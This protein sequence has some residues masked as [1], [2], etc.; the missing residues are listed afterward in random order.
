M[1]KR[2]AKTAVYIIAALGG[3]MGIICGGGWLIWSYA[4]APERV[5]KRVRQD[6]QKQFAGRVQVRW[7]ELSP[8]LRLNV[9]G[10]KVFLP[11]GKRSVIAIPRTHVRF[12]PERFLHGEQV[13]RRVELSS[14]ELR[15]V[16]DVSAD[17]WNLSELLRRR[18]KKERRKEVPRSLLQDGLYVENGSVSIRSRKIFKSP[19]PR[20]VEGVNLRLFRRSPGGPLWNLTGNVSRGMLKGMVFSGRFADQGFWLDCVIEDL[21]VNKALLKRIPVGKD[22]EELFHPRGRV[23]GDIG[24]HVPSDQSG[25]RYNA[26]IDLR[27]LNSRTK[28]YGAR[29]YEMAGQVLIV[30]GKVIFRDISGRLPPDELGLKA[31]ECQPAKVRINGEYD[32]KSKNSWVRIEAADMPLTRESVKEI[33]EVGP[34]IW[35][36]LQPDGFTDVSIKVE[37]APDKKT[38]FGVRADLKEVNLTVNELPFNPSK[39]VGEVDVTEK[40]VKLRDV[41]GVVKQGNRTARLILNGTFDTKGHPRD[42]TV[43]M[44]NFRLSEKTVRAIP[45]FGEDFW[46]AFRPDGTVEGTITLRDNGEKL[47]VAGSIHLSDATLRPEF[48]PLTLHGVTATVH[49][50]DNG[51]Q[52]SRLVGDMKVVSGEDEEKEHVELTGQLEPDCRSGTI[53]LRVPTCD[54]HRA[55][56]RAVPGVGDA[57]WE[58]L[59]P[60]GL[61]ALNGRIAYDL[62]DEDPV[63]YLIRLGLRNAR[64]TWNRLKVTMSSMTGTVIVS[65][66]NVLIPHVQGV[67]ASGPFDASG[68]V[69]RS[70][71]G[72]IRYNGT[73]EYR[74]V[75]LRRLLYEVT[76][77]ERNT[78]GRISGLIEMGGR[79][80]DTKRIAGTGTMELADGKVWKAPVLL[81]LI[82]VLHLSS[83]GQ[84]G[85]FDEG[86][87]RC[88]FDSESVQIQSLRLTSPAAELTGQGTVGLENG[89]LDLKMVAATLPTGG[90]PVIGQALRVVLRPIERQLI[91]VEVTG[92]LSDP[93]YSPKPLQNVT[94]PI[95]SLFGLITSPFRGDGKKKEKK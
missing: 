86:K 37:D 51:V 78:Q 3:M 21:I 5:Q 71:K 72:T 7:A 91:R 65:D 22:L 83:P 80:G 70:S 69:T 59:Q 89:E 92:T 44:S 25:A 68:F 85:R 27:G 15:I 41:R 33:P 9:E 79:V 73:L 50:D 94:R 8:S 60:Q 81:G 55:L 64:A 75:N 47:Q 20:V 29:M 12:D 19:D 45:D 35:K 58:Q 36:E 66:T 6:L 61:V 77:E 28:F 53:S 42:L 34:E 17:E 13:P 2:L 24:I 43:Q 88:T 54:L 40:R 38:R 76:G 11:S 23:R 31:E 10:I 1:L 14:P 57:L 74:R 30:G 95:T 87:M 32:I 26:R 84:Y 52:I 90:L 56:V 48:V 4:A 62:D 82:D 46:E 39:L 18:K 93:K 67:I 16:H 63:S 49:F